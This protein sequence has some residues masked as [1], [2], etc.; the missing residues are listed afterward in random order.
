LPTSN[1][2]FYSFS[3]VSLIAPC[4]VPNFRFVF[5]TLTFGG[6]KL[7]LKQS[8]LLLTWFYYLTFIKQDPKKKKKLRFFVLPIKRKNYTLNRAPIAHKNWSKE[9][10]YF[11][12]FLLR[13]SFSALLC[14]ENVLKTSN[15]ALLF[16]LLSQKN[17]PT[18]ETNLF[19][20]K[21]FRFLFFFSDKRFFSYKTLL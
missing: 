3:F 20:L 9:Q 5:E 14:E 12:F 4:T 15:Q 11:Q 6:K 16:V 13:I 19:F 10:Y 7:L 2:I 21:N 1:K 17:S 8:Y 18:L